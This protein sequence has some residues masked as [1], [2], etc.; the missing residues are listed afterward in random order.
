MTS[1]MHENFTYLVFF[2]TLSQ[3]A[4]GALIFREMTIMRGGFE[5]ISDRYKKRSLL[6]ITFL[7][8]LSL[9][10]AFLHLGYPVNA[11]NALNNIGRSWLSREILSL[12]L[13]IVALLIYL[14]V[15]FKDKSWRAAKT[16]SLVAIFL[17]ISFIFSMI[18]LYLV[19]SIPSWYHPFT[20]VSYIITTL[21]CGF[22]LLAVIIGNKY[23]R[24][25]LNTR[26]FI[27]IL[28]FFSLLNTIIFPGSFLKQGIV[29]FIVR[30]ALTFMSLILLSGKKFIRPSNKTFI[31]LVILFFI[32]FSSEIINRYIFFLSFDKHGL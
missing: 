24:I 14:I 10:I 26:P 23:D 20:P 7:L 8:I 29:L 11:L 22:V 5:F 27:A 15:I 21:L 25:I 32:L 13:L 3:T 28:I 1:D 2:T 16:L 30:T 19:P 17:G 18:K 9:A 4:V 6:I 31:P 12:S